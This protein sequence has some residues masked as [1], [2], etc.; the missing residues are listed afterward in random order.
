MLTYRLMMIFVIIYVGYFGPSLSP[1]G[2]KLEIVQEFL[3]LTQATL[4]PVYTDF[5]PDPLTRYQIGFVSAG[6]LILQVAISLIVVLA[7]TCYNIKL[8]CRK[9]SNKRRH[10]KQMKLNAKSKGAAAKHPAPPGQV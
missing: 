8:R 7:D 1:G 3:L 2:R 5:V 10:K 6:L 4:L 9:C